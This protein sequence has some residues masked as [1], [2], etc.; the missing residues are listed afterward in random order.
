[1][2]SSTLADSSDVEL[3]GILVGMALALSVVSVYFYR[4]ALHQAKE[5]GLFDMETSY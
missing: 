4:W 5:Q 1:M 2:V 3:V